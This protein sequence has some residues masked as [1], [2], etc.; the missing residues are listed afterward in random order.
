MVVA[1]SVCVSVSFTSGA[2]VSPEHTGTF[3]VGNE[4]KQ[5]CGIFS[6][7]HAFQRLS[8]PSL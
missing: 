1:M 8:T 7:T 5:T 3:S 4:G 2:F 6:E